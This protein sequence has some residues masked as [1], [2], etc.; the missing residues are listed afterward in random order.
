M[1]SVRAQTTLFQYLS[2]VENLL[3][4][5]FVL[6]L[7][8]H[9]ILMNSGRGN[10][11][12]FAPGAA[13]TMGLC[14]MQVLAY[15]K[16]ILIDFAVFVNGVTFALSG[17]GGFMVTLFITI[18]AFGQMWF[19]LYKQSI[20]C[21]EDYAEDGAAGNETDSNIMYYYD[22]NYD[23][24]IPQESYVEDCEK[25]KPY[26]F[27]E[28][29]YW[30]I[31]KSYTMMLGEI[32]TS[33]FTWDTFALILFCIFVFIEVLILLNILIAI[34]SDLFAVVTNE[35]AAIVFWSN[36]LAFITD[37]DMVTNGK[38]IGTSRV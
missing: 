8:Y 22:D 29:L 11:N 31:W 23:D 30:S 9:A 15:L 7:V 4:L 34:I 12:H 17:L 6:M 37:M 25:Q 3:N 13:I 18:I 24:L 2:D 20:I 38:S 32:E 35:R 10:D 33:V 36:R 1:I 16:S 5:S 27:C 21:I 14:Y 26:P 28:S 19:T